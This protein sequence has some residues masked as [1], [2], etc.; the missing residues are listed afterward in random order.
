ML[1]P[2]GGVW[3][4]VKIC[5]WFWVGLEKGTVPTETLFG[6]LR[7]LKKGRFQLRHFFGWLGVKICFWFWVRRVADCVERGSF[8]ASFLG[9]R[10]CFYS[11]G[12][13]GWVLKFDFWFLFLRRGGLV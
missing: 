11:L 5:F 10:R 12:V 6:P 9:G 4:G 3:L 2:F 7:A 1:L 13:C 8:R